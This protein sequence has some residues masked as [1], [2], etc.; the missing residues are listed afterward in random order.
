MAKM[1]PCWPKKYFILFCF[2]DPVPRMKQIVSY[3]FSTKLKEKCFLHLF[4]NYVCN[5][6]LCSHVRLTK[7]FLLENMPINRLK[8]FVESFLPSLTNS[9]FVTSPS[10][11]AYFDD[12]ASS[13]STCGAKL[14]KLIMIIFL[15]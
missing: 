3:Q 15:F 1:R 9:A 8:L 11:S 14:V 6:T 2:Q 5:N 4:W 13:R 10:A 12:A 7:V